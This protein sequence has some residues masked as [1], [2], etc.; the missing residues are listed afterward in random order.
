MEKRS[1][2]LFDFDGTLI[3]G[4]SILRYVA[5]A[6][7]MRRMTLGEGLRALLAGVK[8]FLHII[9]DN[10]MKT[11]VIAFWTRMSREEREAFDRAFADTLITAM[12]VDGKRALQRAQEAGKAVL[13]VSASTENYMRFVAER[14]NAS[15]LLCTLIDEKGNVSRNCK[16]KE[17]LARID[18]W[19]LE[20]GIVCDQESTV[21]YGDTGSDYLMLTHY[22]AGTC[23][24]AK[25]ALKK[26]AKGK[27]PF[28]IWR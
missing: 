9:D 4:D 5:Y 14:L 11:C 27:L 17:K 10:Q 6:R 24:N 13:I 23:V 26:K 15:A 7:K 2:A 28:V 12:Y 1:L 19:L 8:Y 25:R 22:G 18:A 20:N 16:G 21:S 3:H